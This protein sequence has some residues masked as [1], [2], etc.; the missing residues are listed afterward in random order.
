MTAARR[1]RRRR[2]GFGRLA[3]MLVLALS[4]CAVNPATGES[5]FTAF[6]SVDDEMRIRD[7][8]HPKL[9][10]RFG[11][12]YDDPEL[13]AYVA[14][15]GRRLTAVSEMPDLDYGFILLNNPTVNAFALPGGYLY[16]TRGLLALAGNEAELAGVL[17]HEIG[18]VVARHAAQRY[19]RQVLTDFGVGV[20]ALFTF[21]G[22]SEAARAEAVSQLQRY[23]RDQEH[24]ADSLG[25]RYMTR[26]GYDPRAMISFL[27]KLKAHRAFEAKLRGLPEDA[28]QAADAMLSHPRTSERLRQLID[29]AVDTAVGTSRLARDR[30]LER[31]DGLVYGDDPAHGMMRG[32]AFVHPGRGFRF[33]V[34]PDF[35]VRHGLG[36]LSAR[37]PKGSLILFDAAKDAFRGP[38]IRYLSE[39]WAAELTLL[40]IE[41]IQ[42]NGME[43]A[44]GWNRVDSDD[45]PRDIRLLAIR[46]DRDTLYRFTFLST[47]E[48]TLRLA[49]ALRGVT[50]SFR[51]LTPQQRAAYQPLRLAVVSA[52]AGDTLSGLAAR[53]PLPYFRAERLAV[54]NGLPL[55]ATIETGD[56]LKIVRQ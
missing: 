56:R 10:A 8:E 7:Q 36:W 39:I 15:V 5:A 25:V 29:R 54:L 55:G 14:E 37:G 24:E 4:G 40:D 35:R 49:A 38:P 43:A 31:I 46:F 22:G 17:A 45:G 33:E 11:G 18:H 47:P 1:H 53:M 19:S 32:T 16:L 26:A 21:G 6:M 3:P 27:N 9:V 23:S 20:A 34:P 44:T 30:F 28:A 51:R 12:I 52:A 2:A 42:V 41:T 48:S 13:A 50:Y